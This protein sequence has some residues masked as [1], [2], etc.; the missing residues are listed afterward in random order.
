MNPALEMEG[1]ANDSKQP[2]KM[3]L[4]RSTTRS[5]THRPPITVQI[6]H[7]YL[8]LALAMVGVFSGLQPVV[9]NDYWWHLRIGQ[10]IA[11]EHRVPTTAL[12]AWTIP[13]DKPYIYGEWLG[14]LQLYLLHEAGG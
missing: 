7:L 13:P 3:T 4:E 9:P 2:M 6:Q 10:I 14:E 12:F 5:E 1:I 8:V 11:L